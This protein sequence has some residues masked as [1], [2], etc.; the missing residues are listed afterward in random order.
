VALEQQTRLR[1]LGTQVTEQASALHA[2][3]QAYRELGGGN[4]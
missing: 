4:G 1:E 2:Y 3:R